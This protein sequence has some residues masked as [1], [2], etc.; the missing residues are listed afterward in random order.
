MIKPEIGKTRASDQRKNSLRQT[1]LNSATGTNQLLP[2]DFPSYGQSRWDAMGAVSA[3]F[4]SGSPG[5]A[6]TADLVIN[7]RKYSRLYALYD[8]DS[9][10]FFRRPLGLPLSTELIPNLSR[11]FSPDFGGILQDFP[12][13]FIE[14]SLR[15][16]RA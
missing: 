9:Q 12:N 1:L 4:G 5:R 10:V 15:G 8:Q 2:G 6:R 11:A 13:G 14:L 16:D 7:S 3:R